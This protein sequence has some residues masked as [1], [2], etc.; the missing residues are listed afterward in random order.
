MRDIAVSSTEQAVKKS[1]TAYSVLPLKMPRS[2]LLILVLVT[3]G[4]N[5]VQDGRAHKC[6]LH[7]LLVSIRREQARLGRR[8]RCGTRR[9]E[10]SSAR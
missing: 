1:F 7:G 5:A 6:S 8:R 10:S 2:A 4:R 9:L 3:V